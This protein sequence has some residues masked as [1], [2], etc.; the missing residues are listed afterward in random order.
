MEVILSAYFAKARVVASDIVL[1]DSC[2]ALRDRVQR[3]VDM[4]PLLMD[5]EEEHLN[6]T[7]KIEAEREF[8]KEIAEP[9]AEQRVYT[10]AALTAAL[11]AGRE[12]SMQRLSERLGSGGAWNPPSAMMGAAVLGHI[13]SPTVPS[14]GIASVGANSLDASREKVN[15]GLGNGLS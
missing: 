11:L 9:A 1:S 14:N 3:V 8:D 13:R 15:G 12:F 2:K 7:E 4:D 6:D 5:I 10:P